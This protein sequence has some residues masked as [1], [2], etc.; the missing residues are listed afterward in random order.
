MLVVYRK[1]DKELAKYFKR[2]FGGIKSKYGT[3]RRSYKDMEKLD[4]IIPNV[5]YVSTDKLPILEQINYFL[6]F[7]PKKPASI[8]IFN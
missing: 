6:N 3:E 7:L 8:L 5:N 2:N 4:E 1:N